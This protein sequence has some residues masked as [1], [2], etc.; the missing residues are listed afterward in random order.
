MS[1]REFIVLVFA[2]ATVGLIVMAVRRMPWVVYLAS[3]LGVIALTLA[4]LGQYPLGAGST[5]ISHL[6][7]AAVIIVIPTIAAFVVGRLIALNLG[8]A[9][10]FAASCTAYV[11]ALGMVCGLVS[12]S[13]ILTP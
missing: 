7:V 12:L 9:Y 4:S 11:F 5:L 6:A 1:D 2:P 10:V 3:L 13:G 8:G